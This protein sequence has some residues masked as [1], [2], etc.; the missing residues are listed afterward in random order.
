MYVL[1][2]C[3]CLQSAALFS[4]YAILQLVHPRCVSED[5]DLRGGGEERNDVKLR[6]CPLQGWLT[7][8]TLSATFPPSTK[9]T[10]YRYDENHP[11]NGDETRH[12]YLP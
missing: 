5:F 9:N 6:E 4:Q 12:F 10:R 7:P 3:S 2:V 1:G 11:F 8:F